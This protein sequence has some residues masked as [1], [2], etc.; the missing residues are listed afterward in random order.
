[1]C[2]LSV[3]LGPGGQLIVVTLA[4]RLGVVGQITTVSLSTSG[5]SIRAHVR[6][7]PC[8]ILYMIADNVLTISLPSSSFSLPSGVWSECKMC[9]SLDT[10]EM[11]VVRMDGHRLVRV[12]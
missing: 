6:L 12:V 3:R 4:I 1:M 9:S 10:V 8:P 5:D 7:P 2:P 11:M